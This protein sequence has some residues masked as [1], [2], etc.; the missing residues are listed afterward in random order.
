MSYSFP[1]GWS[2]SGFLFYEGEGEAG[3][4]F[5]KRAA[6]LS[7]LAALLALALILSLVF[8][9]EGRRNSAF[10]WLDPSFLPL[11]DRIELYGLEGRIILERR[12]NLWVFP[13][14]AGD[15]PIRQTRVEDLLGVLSQRH[16]YPLRASSLEARLSLALEP[17]MASRIIVRAGAG[18]PLVDLLVG[19][20][21]ALI[22]EVYLRSA[23]AREI[24]S[25]EDRFTLFTEGSPQFWFDLR[26]FPPG[27][28]GSLSP[29]MVQQAEIVLPEGSLTLQRSGGGWVSSGQSVPDS[30]RVEAWVR[31]VLE[32]EG[33]D[34]SVQAPPA[35]EGSI[36]LWFG[37]G[38][39]TTLLLGPPDED[40]RRC[41][42]V[43]GS[44]LVYVLGE[45]GV[46]R[47]F[48]GP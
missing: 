43:E 7:A 39:S 9:P 37:D 23:D 1:W 27:P 32:A 47:L 3:L 41:L 42:W 11:I 46:N 5:R 45:W 29:G 35:A 30:F 16:P 15:L 34:F 22:R 13:T 36:T 10:A 48:G 17:G 20:A 18:L 12:N 19:T 38:S 4:N 26:L 14:E 6:L 2:S 28:A 24:Y 31:S 44:P 25:G 8:D 33:E 21:D 40:Q